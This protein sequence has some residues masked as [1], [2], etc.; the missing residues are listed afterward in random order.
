M[1]AVRS[2]ATRV[3]ED[4]ATECQLYTNYVLVLLKL[5]KFIDYTAKLL[6]TSDADTGMDH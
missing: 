2:E 5:Y 1:S 3:V 6:V 4:C